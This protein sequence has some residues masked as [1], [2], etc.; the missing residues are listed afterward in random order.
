M[1]ALHIALVILIITTGIKAQEPAQDDTTRVLEEIKIK[2]AKR[3]IHADIK[4][5][6]SID[7]YLAASEQVSFIKRGAYA[8]EPLLNNMTIERSSITIDGMHIFGA[9]TDKMDPVSTYL[10][11]NNL[12][13]IDIRSG[14][15]GNMHGATIGGNI[16]FKRKVTPF[17]LLKKWSGIYQTGVEWNNKQVFN[18][19]NLSYSG[20]RFVTDGSIAYRKAGNY[21]DGN[22]EEVQHSQYSKLNA[23]AGL[24][25]K[26]S[27]LSS[28]RLDA[29][30][31]VAKDVGYP[32]LPMDLWLSRAI[33]TSATYKQLFEKGSIRSWNTKLYF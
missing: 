25:Y 6:T 24:A 13:S 8:W 19:L 16:D 4:Q 33:I 27:E 9:C 18:L 11:S 2:A 10:E 5:S 26:T 29:I 7:E 28:I 23:S 14:Q 20:K 21:Y 15:E 31:D 32:A 30:F 22:Q 12:S 3:N 17:G 1:K